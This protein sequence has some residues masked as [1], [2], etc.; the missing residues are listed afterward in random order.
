MPAGCSSNSCGVQAAVLLGRGAPGGCAHMEGPL[1]NRFG[2]RI[3][4]TLGSDLEQVIAGR[5]RLQGSSASLK[6]VQ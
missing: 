6:I 3:K 4:Q 1:Q 2:S 5:T